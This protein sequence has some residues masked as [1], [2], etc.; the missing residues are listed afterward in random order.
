MHHLKAV[1]PA[2]TVYAL[3]AKS[4]LDAAANAVALGGAGLIML[5]VGGDEILSA[6]T[7]VKQKMA[8]SALREETERPP[9]PTPGLPADGARRGARRQRGAHRGGF[10]PRAG[11]DSRPGLP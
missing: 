4:A 10:A 7:A 3:A 6:L 5:P 1:V 2:V 11:V 8:D 9:A